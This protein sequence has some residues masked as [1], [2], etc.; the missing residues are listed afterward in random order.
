MSVNRDGE[1]ELIERKSSKLE[2]WDEMGRWK[3]VSAS[4]KRAAM[5]INRLRRG[6]ISASGV[7]RMF[8]HSSRVYQV[9]ISISKVE[10][11]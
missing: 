8:T 10:I 9:A 1:M 6:I 4:G 11:A 5:A 2:F 3:I 7:G